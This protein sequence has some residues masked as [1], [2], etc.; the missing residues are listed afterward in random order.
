MMHYS[1]DAQFMLHLGSERLPVTSLL[2]I[3]DSRHQNQI[4]FLFTYFCHWLHYSG[5]AEHNKHIYCQLL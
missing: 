2:T 1:G 5:D 4:Y 3:L